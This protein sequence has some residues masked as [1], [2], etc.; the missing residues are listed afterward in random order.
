MPG[1]LVCPGLHTQTPALQAGG[2]KVPTH[3]IPQPPQLLTSVVSST[4]AGG[5][6]PAVGPAGGVG[7]KDSVPVQ[8]LP[9]W[10]VKPAAVQSTLQLPQFRLSVVRSVHVVELHNPCPAGQQLPFW[11]FNPSGHTFPQP[12][13]LFGSVCSFVQ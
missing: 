10:Q 4:Q 7:Q 6:G 5:G 11:Q 1:Q 12:P 2:E 8:Q 3:T 9:F 13:Q